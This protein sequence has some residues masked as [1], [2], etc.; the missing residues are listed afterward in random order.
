M[1]VYIHTHPTNKTKKNRESLVFSIK[2][3]FDGDF[4]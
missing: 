1:Y 3:M 2:I 4:S